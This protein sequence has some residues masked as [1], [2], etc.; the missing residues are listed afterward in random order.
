MDDYDKLSVLFLSPSWQ[1]NGLGIPIITQSLANDLWTVDTDTKCIN[2]TCAV[3][4]EQLRI[5]PADVE[6]AKRWNIS[7][8]GAKLPRGLKSELAH[9]E[10]A[11]L[12][13][14][15]VSYYRHILQ[16]KN[17]DF[18][19][20]HIPTLANG[21]LNVREFCQEDGYSPKVILF[22][23]SLPKTPN[24]DIDEPLLLEWLQEADFV[25]SV[26]QGLKMH[27]DDY[28]QN[29][30]KVRPKHEL[31]IPN[32]PLEYFEL[33]RKSK[34]YPEG[35][36]N[37]TVVTGDIQD[38][39]VKGIDYKLAIAASANATTKLLQHYTPRN[40]LR[41][42]L[43]TVGTKEERDGWK[44]RF[45]EI[46]HNVSKDDKRLSFMYKNVRDQNEFKGILRR[47]SLYILPL[48]KES[49][50]F[51]IEALVACSAGIPVLVAKN[52]GFADVLY[53]MLA[54]D[55]FLEVG[56]TDKDVEKWGNRI[57][58]KILNTRDTADE[59]SAVKQGLIVNSSIEL[60]HLNFINTIIGK[61]SSIIINI[62]TFEKKPIF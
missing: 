54:H 49:A 29:L 42:C 15:T 21:A 5:N 30:D 27:I 51:G 45:D 57:M 11:W 3:V 24:G 61:G 34:E 23:H 19:V 58:Q 26:G 2:I 55:S 59:A 62:F 44:C 1:F 47:T 20:G 4:E 6:D 17:I 22:V 46:L 38:A 8:K 48:Q 40:N 60:S 10:L 41:V 52:S 25:F 32:C 43:L 9:P 18:V 36:Q 39:D 12:D 50:L 31:Y 37:I 56:G 7:L 13:I 14:H 28:L 35:Q 53:T 33:D 16:G